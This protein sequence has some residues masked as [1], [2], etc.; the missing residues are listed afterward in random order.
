MLYEVITHIL[1]YVHKQLKLPLETY[2]HVITPLK[3]EELNMHPQGE[4]RNNFV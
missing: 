3:T 2:K 4:F 1:H